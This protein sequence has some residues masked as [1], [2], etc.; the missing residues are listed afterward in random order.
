[1]ALSAFFE[2]VRGDVEAVHGGG[3]VVQ[4]WT[5]S[6]AEKC[7]ARLALGSRDLAELHKKQEQDP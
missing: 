1:M 4:A 2:R 6:P 5:D 7:K 3:I